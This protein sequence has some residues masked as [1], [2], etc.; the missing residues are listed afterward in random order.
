MSLKK[1]SN[2]TSELF[3][4]MVSSEK[5]E[6]R[7]HL[8]F[9]SLS[10]KGQSKEE[11]RSSTKSTDMKKLQRLLVKGNLLFQEKKQLERCMKSQRRKRRLLVNVKD[12]RRKLTL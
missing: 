8:D 11:C 6:S 4:E 2:L 1:K 10:F 3:L 7:S 12:S 9:L 5:W